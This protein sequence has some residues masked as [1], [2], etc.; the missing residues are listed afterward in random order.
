MALLN[1]IEKIENDLKLLN[2]SQ[3]YRILSNN[4]L[5]KLVNS[6]YVNEEKIPD[7]MASC[8]LSAST[9]CFM[10]SILPIKLSI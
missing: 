9:A 4:N 10:L 5:V 7:N 8:D 2:L 6:L 1:E 3:K